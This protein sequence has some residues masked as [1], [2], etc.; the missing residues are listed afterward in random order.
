MVFFNRTILIGVSTMGVGAL[1]SVM[2]LAQ[3]YWHLVVIR[4]GLGFFA[5]VFN[6]VCRPVIAE[7]FDTKTRGLANGIFTWGIYYG[8]GFTYIL[9]N[10]AVPA[11]IGGMG[12]RIVCVLASIWA[13][14]LGIAILFVKDPRRRKSALTQELINEGRMK[15]I[16]SDLD[17]STSSSS[18][19]S[20]SD[21]DDENSTNSKSDTSLVVQGE[22]EYW[23]TVGRNW[24]KPTLILLFIAAAVRQTAG[25]SWAFNT[26]LYIEEY[27]PETN[28]GYQIALCSIIGGG[29]GV[30]VGG[31]LSDLAVRKFGLH[32]RLWILAGSLGI[33]T[34]LSIGVV[35]CPPPGL[36][37]FLLFYYLFCRYRK[38]AMSLSFLVDLSPP[39]GF[40]THYIYSFYPL[41]SSVD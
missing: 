20:G 14:P 17:L 39:T 31:W 3:E 6:P 18:S 40:L 16:D 30:F 13:I 9:G 25:N 11:D 5:A 36:F 22:K 34:P 28:P 35:L 24:K 10:Y 7:I 32:S 15:N 12:W 19:S 23:K 41:S 33:A 4:M 26:Q 2:G 8:Y 38:V 37:L 29:F 1:C 21:D 27:Y